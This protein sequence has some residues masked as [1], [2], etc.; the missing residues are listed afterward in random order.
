M[1]SQTYYTVRSIV[2]FTFWFSFFAGLYAAYVL[3]I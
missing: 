1:H 2:R 3:V